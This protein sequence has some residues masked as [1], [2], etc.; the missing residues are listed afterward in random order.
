MRQVIIK[1][2]QT[3]VKGGEEGI[4][5]THTP[6]QSKQHT[7]V[8]TTAAIQ[9]GY[10]CGFRWLFT[11]CHLKWKLLDNWNDPRVLAIDSKCQC[12]KHV[13]AQATGNRI[14]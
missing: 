13:N 14:S 3:D 4:P 1:S 2:P 9:Y 12:P 7:V 6:N 8:R 10:Q 11:G 5:F